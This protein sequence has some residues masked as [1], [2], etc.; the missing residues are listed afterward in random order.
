MLWIDAKL[1]RHK[2][3]PKGHGSGRTVKGRDNFL[4]ASSIL[5]RGIKGGSE[6]ESQPCK[7]FKAKTANWHVCAVCLLG[8]LSLLCP[9]VMIGLLSCSTFPP[10]LPFFCPASIPIYSQL[11]WTKRRLN[12][13]S[14]SWLCFQ[15]SHNILSYAENRTLRFSPQKNSSFCSTFIYLFSIFCSYIFSFS[16]SFLCIALPPQA[17]C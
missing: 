12:E 14:S 5:M 9:G 11:E 4:R 1:V 13:L 16:T 2:P 15:L 10:L 17:E 8:R 3:G 7:S 6:V